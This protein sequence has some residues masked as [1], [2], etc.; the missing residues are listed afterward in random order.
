[1]DPYTARPAAEVG[2]QPRFPSWG[3]SWCGVVVPSTPGLER[4]FL[5]RSAPLPSRVFGRV[6]A[7]SYV[8]RWWP[9]PVLSP[10]GE[11]RATR[12]QAP[13]ESVLSRRD[14]QGHESAR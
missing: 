6:T 13:R 1:M 11:I 5:L 3:K 4:Y 14:R 2:G 12:M 9:S 7:A 8:T 10:W